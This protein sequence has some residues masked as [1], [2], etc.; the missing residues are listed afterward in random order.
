MNI[1]NKLIIQNLNFSYKDKEILKN[2]NLEL[3]KGE[4]VSILGESGCGKTTMF[5]LIAGILPNNN[6]IIINQENDELIKIGYMQQKDLLLEH[7]NIE[8]NI[9][10]PMII[11]NFNKQEALKRANEILAEFNML[12]CKNKYPKEL[13]GGMKQRIAFIR[14][15]VIK[16]SIYLLD[17]PFNALDTITK[18]QIHKWFKTIQKK[19]KLSTLII[20]H[21]IDEAL[22]LSDKIYLLKDKKLIQNIKTKDEILNYLNG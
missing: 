4:I 3:K 1:L 20:T 14:T 6:A 9:M 15:M 8:E 10:L 16:A 2:I 21:D 7:K 11:N 13:S 12:D 5:N 22:N 19:Y 18:I 17:E